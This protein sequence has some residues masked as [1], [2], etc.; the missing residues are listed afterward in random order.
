MKQTE[1]F[2]TLFVCLLI[3]ITVVIYVYFY[4]QLKTFGQLMVIFSP[5]FIFAFAGT[6]IARRD[7][8]I[9]K[10]L[11]QNNQLSKTVEL[12]WF[13]AFKHDLALYLT[14]LII[15]LLPIIFDQ[16]PTLITIFQAI[17]IY[18]VLIYLRYIY[19]REI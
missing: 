19:W 14:P 9:I 2:L 13:L 12:N 6:L 5:I 10:R 8:K 16:K 7:Q 1:T 17:I 3:T 18:L 4:D 15:L 11:R